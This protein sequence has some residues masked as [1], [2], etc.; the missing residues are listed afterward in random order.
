MTESFWPAPAKINLFLHVTGRRPD[1]YHLLQTVFQFLDLEDRLEFGPR[2][3]DLIVRHTDNDAVPAGDDLAIRAAHALRAAAGNTPGVD[4]RIS[5][6]IPMGGGLGG[7]S[8][9]AAT[10]LA[11]LNSLWNLGF[12][13]AELGRIGL[14]LGADVPVFL[15]GRA[16]WAEGVGEILEPVA[17]PEDWYLIV[18]P[19]CAVSTA[20][21]FDHPDLTRHTPAITIRAFLEGAGS[22]DCEAVVRKLYPQVASAIDWLRERGDARMT[23]TG[24]CVFLRSRSESEVRAVLKALPP[25]WTG[26][27]ARGLNRSPLLERMARG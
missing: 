2:A 12:D 20:K 24:S 13:A 17:V 1:G 9:D 14:K 15:F 26:L 25:Q 18:H 27:V 16:A 7:G 5:K 21:V 10:T 11:A 3:D 19:G 23:G 22:N 6:R 4:I 8:S